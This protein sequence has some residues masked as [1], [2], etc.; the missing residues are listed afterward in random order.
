M[1]HDDLRL[2]INGGLG[3]VSLD[4]TVLCQ[5]DAAVGVGEV[6]RCLAVGL[7]VGRR[8]GGTVFLASLS[9]ALRLGRFLLS[10]P[11]AGISPPRRP[12]YCLSSSAS[13]ASAAFSQRSTSATSSTSRR[14]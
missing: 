6:A 7:R 12:P 4:V 5:K 2:S 13:A 1:R 11:Q 3:I 9:E 14:C 10:A 8:R